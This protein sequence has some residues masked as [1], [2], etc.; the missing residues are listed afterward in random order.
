MFLDVSE[1]SSLMVQLL[2]RTRKEDIHVIKP[3]D[4]PVSA[5][6]TGINDGCTHFP[7]DKLYEFLGYDIYLRWLNIYT[8]ISTIIAKAPTAYIN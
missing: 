3:F 2:C 4:G 6:S 7:K 8:N 1:A 5:L